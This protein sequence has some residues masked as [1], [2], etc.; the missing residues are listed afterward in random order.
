MAQ[1]THPG[2]KTCVPIRDVREGRKVQQEGHV[3]QRERRRRRKE[4]HIGLAVG[5]NGNA[6]SRDYKKPSSLS[7][8]WAVVLHR[9]GP[10]VFLAGAVQGC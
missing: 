7:S 3:G 9:K 6:R 8:L 2:E 10:S 4:T 1:P 5:P